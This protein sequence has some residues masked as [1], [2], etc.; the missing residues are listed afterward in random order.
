M[1]LATVE[2]DCFA[3][4]T[5]D[6]SPTVGALPCSRPRNTVQGLPCIPLQRCGDGTPDASSSAAWRGTCSGKRTTHCRIWATTAMTWKAP[7]ACPS[8]RTPCNTSRGSD[9]GTPRKPAAG[10][11]DQ[12]IYEERSS[13]AERRSVSGTARV[14]R[15]GTGTSPS[16]DFRAALSLHKSTKI[17]LNP[18][19]QFGGRHVAER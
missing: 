2:P 11:A 12:Q 13:N 19:E 15:I 1:Q 4:S 14:G 18:P 9:P 5:A 10:V 3:A 17:L 7:C 6:H 8:A 16:H